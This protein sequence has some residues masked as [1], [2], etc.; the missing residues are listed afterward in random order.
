MSDQAIDYSVGFGNL[1]DITQ[2]NKGFTPDYFNQTMMVIQISP[3]YCPLSSQKGYSNLG[4]ELECTMISYDYH[5]QSTL[6]KCES[7][8]VDKS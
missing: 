7:S 3:K 2:N 6:Y 5:L 8:G 4:I 1:T